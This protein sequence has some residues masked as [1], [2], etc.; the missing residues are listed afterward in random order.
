MKAIS[1]SLLVLFTTL[2]AVDLEAGHRHCRGC[3]D[4]YSRTNV[5]F[6]MGHG[7][8]V[9]P[10]VVPIQQGPFVTQPIYYTPDYAYP[11]SYV[12]YQQPVIMQ[13]RPVV[14]QQPGFNFGF[15]VW[16]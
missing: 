6:N 11:V 16:N 15:S 9:A 8:Y 7:P 2:F 12:D 14:V 13:P 3:Y 1:L 4:R 10:V 5:N